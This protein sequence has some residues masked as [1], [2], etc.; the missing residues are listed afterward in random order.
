MDVFQVISKYIDDIEAL[1]DIDSVN[2][3]RIAKAIA[4]DRSLSVLL[5]CMNAVYTDVKCR[6][7]ENAMLLYNVESTKL[8]LY[9]STSE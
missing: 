5:L 6:T 3:D 9:D 2:L 1:G 7:P 8:T 4:K